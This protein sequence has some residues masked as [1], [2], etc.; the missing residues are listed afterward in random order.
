MDVLDR[1]RLARRGVAVA[2]P[3]R[4]DSERVERRRLGA[5]PQLRDGYTPGN[6]AKFGLARAAKALKLQKAVS[7]KLGPSFRLEPGRP[8]EIA[9]L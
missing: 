1:G 4:D 7:T 5:R 8:G 3:Q 2:V 9:A 6:L